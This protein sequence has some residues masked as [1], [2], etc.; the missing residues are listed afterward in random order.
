MTARNHAM[1]NRVADA[2]LGRLQ[3][4]GKSNLMVWLSS[5]KA[6]QRGIAVDAANL[7]KP[8]LFLMS[9]GWGP[10]T[11]YGTIAGGGLDVRAEAQFTVLAIVDQPVTSRE[12]EQELNDLCADVIAAIETD[13]Q[14]GDLLGTGYVHVDGYKPEVELSGAG[15]SVA[16]LEL[17]ATWLWDTDSP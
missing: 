16:S 2:L 1:M 11:P 15:F 3:L 7:P 5:P 14:L 9:A 6:V 10:V 17:N 12:A 4:I 8:A 13:Y